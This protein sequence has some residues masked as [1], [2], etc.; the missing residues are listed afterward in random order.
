LRANG[1]MPILS[2]G[3][4]DIMDGVSTSGEIVRE[5]PFEEVSGYWTLDYD[6]LVEDL[7][8][9]DQALYVKVEGKGLVIISGCAHSGIVN[10][11][12]QAKKTSGVDHIYA[13]VGG[14]HL[15]TSND[16]RIR[17]SVDE[18]ERMDPKIIHPCH[19]TGLKAISFLLERFENRCKPIC[20]GDIVE[21]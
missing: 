11:I 4:V 12:I 7:M 10:T 9:D 21:L 19:C 5:T 15:T 17:K 14:L 13:I 16:E 1:G 18:I 6:K 3:P 8:L 2:R 20:T